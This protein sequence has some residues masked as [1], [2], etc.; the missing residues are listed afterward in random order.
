M[1]GV[2]AGGQLV[3]DVLV[4]GGRLPGRAHG[5][6]DYRLGGGSLARQRSAPCTGAVRGR[7]R[8]R[9]AHLRRAARRGPRARAP[10]LGAATAASGWRWR[11]RRGSSSWSRCTACCCAARWSCPIDLR[12]SEPERAVRLAGARAR[13]GRAARQRLARS[14]RRRRPST[15]T[16]RWPCSTPRGT[17]AA[18][19]PVELTARN[20]LGQRAGVRGGARARP[21][22]ALALPDAAGP[23]RRPLDPDPQRDL[24]HH[25]R[26]PRALRHRA[27]ARRAE[28][29]G[30][31]DHARL[32]RAD[33]A[34]AAA[35]RR[36]RAPADA[37]LG[38]ARRRPDRPGAARA[39]RG[40][41]GAGGADLRDDRGLLA[42]RHLRLAAARGRGAPRPDGEI[43]VRGDTVAAGRARRRRLAAH[44][45]PRRL[46]RRR[47]TA[48]SPGARPTRSSPAGRTSRRPRSRRCCSSTRRS[49]TPASTPARTPSGARRSSP[50]SCR[51]RAPRRRPRSSGPTARERLARYKVPKEVRFVD[52]LPRTGSGKLLRRELPAMNETEH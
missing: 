17:T 21:R 16:P 2:V 8:R 48:R 24:R 39:G 38:A 10:R 29:P 7:V 34:R 28:R 30:A 3:A 27:R 14:R 18:P 20:F 43:L 46:R 41:G 36:P 5:G 32:A 12:L 31:A 25:R 50:R 44:R 15:S 49:P 23:R 1:P 42:D 6:P 22:R 51:G 37:P 19:K 26:A 11:C 47:A 52:A 35:R 13:G 9:G 33:D 40:G 4:V 45:R